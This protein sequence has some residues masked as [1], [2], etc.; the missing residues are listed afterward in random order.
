MKFEQ[1]MEKWKAR[2]QV[3]FKAERELFLDSIQ[4]YAADNDATP[5]RALDLQAVLEP[6]LHCESVEETPLPYVLNVG[7]GFRPL[8]CGRRTS[9]GVGVNVVGVDPLGFGIGEALQ[10][11]TSQ[12]PGLIAS[13][14]FVTSIVG[15]EMNAF[16][17]PNSFHAVWS[18]GTLLDALDPEKFVIQCVRAVKTGG[19]VCIKL[20]L[21]SP[22]T[23]WKVKGYDGGKMVLESEKGLAGFQ[24]VR[25]ERVEVHTMLDGSLMLKI[26]KHEHTQAD[27]LK[28]LQAKGSGLVLPK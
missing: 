1:W 22:D 12:H 11:M 8:S 14:R 26:R 23:L 24:E 13:R 21:P 28:M 5:P 17:P 15:E 20:G 6:D 19:V 4:K 25:G 3:S 18:E 10:L 16:V 27:V 9:K 7:C 2:L